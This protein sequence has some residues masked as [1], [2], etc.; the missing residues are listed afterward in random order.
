MSPK[1]IWQ[2]SFL[3]EKAAGRYLAR[4]VEFATSYDGG[5]E[6]FLKSGGQRVGR[7]NPKCFWARKLIQQQEERDA[8]S[9]RAR[10]E[11]NDGSCHDG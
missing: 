10:P 4:S 11:D 2:R 3:S 9:G 1:G 5:V 8:E 6:Y 7:I